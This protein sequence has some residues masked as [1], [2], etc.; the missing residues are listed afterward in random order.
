MVGQYCKS[1]SKHWFLAESKKL[2]HYKK[3]QYFNHAIKIIEGTVKITVKGRR[4]LGAIV[5][6]K[7]V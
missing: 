5:G 2:V 3:K 4:Q 6:S 1:W 7:E